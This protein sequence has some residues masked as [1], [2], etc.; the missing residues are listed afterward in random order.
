MLQLY[1]IGTNT[2]LYCLYFCKMSAAL[3]ACFLV[4]YFILFHMCYNNMMLICRFCWKPWSVLLN[5]IAIIIYSGLCC[6]IYSIQTKTFDLLM[7]GCLCLD[8]RTRQSIHSVI[9]VFIHTVDSF[10]FHG[11]NK[12]NIHVCG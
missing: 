7:Y 5:Y 9:S 1:K 2:C 10:Y 12:E 6:T 3:L 11:F 8:Q 4:V